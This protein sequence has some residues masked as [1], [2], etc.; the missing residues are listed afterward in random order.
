MKV[1]VTG[2][3][4][5]GGE[6]VNPAWEAVSRLPR[7]IADAELTTIQIPVVFGKDAAAV[8]RAVD[9]LVPDVVLCVGQAGG[10][11]HI[12][13]EFVGI[14][15]ANARIPDN[16]GNQPVGRIEPDGPDAYFTRLPVFSMVK[17]AQERGVPAAVSYTA[18]TFCCNEIMY[19]VLHMIAT[20][21][22]EMRGGFVHVPY[23]TEQAASMAQGT[24]SMTV[25]M[26]VEGLT[27]MIEAIVTAGDADVA[28]GQIPAG[29]G[30]EH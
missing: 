7:T 3:E 14:N 23:A 28:S 24:P 4:P 10:R 2:F 13:P 15:Y 25:E 21:H 8:A 18:G 9:E 26:I 11:S 30:A 29:Q 6:T 1:L 27:A 20:R 5:F 16:E 17:A 22:P 19:E 12:T